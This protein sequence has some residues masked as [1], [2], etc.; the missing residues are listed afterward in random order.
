[1]ER[2][3]EI[4]ASRIG[5]GGSRAI[6]KIAIVGPPTDYV[7]TNQQQVQAEAS[8]L[9]LRMLSMGKAHRTLAMTTAICTAVAA[10]VPGTVV[11]EL[12]RAGELS[13]R[14]VVRI[15]HPAGVLPVG[16]EVR[17]APDGAWAAVS[18]TTYRTA[19]KITDGCVYVPTS[20]LEGR[21][22]FQSAGLASVG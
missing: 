20:Y 9:V 1:M 3:R 16:A 13:A 6:P 22:W 5:L 12:A 19:R 15:G 8:D 7:T 11:A 18:A 14:H 4:A 2:I 10:A 21:A 17:Q